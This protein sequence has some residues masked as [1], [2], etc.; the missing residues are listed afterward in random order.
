MTAKVYGYAEDD[1]DVEA[2]Q[3]FADVDIIVEDDKAER[4]QYRMLRRFLREGDTLFV[5]H[6]SALRWKD[7]TISAELDYLQQRQ[8]KLRVL[9]LPITL[10]D[11]DESAVS[12]MYQTL[13]EVM[14]AWQQRHENM[15]ILRSARQQ[16]GIKA[17]KKAGRRFGRPTIAYPRSWAQILGQWQAHEISASDA[18]RKLKMSRSTFYRMVKRYHQGEEGGPE[19]CLS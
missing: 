19:G 2:F 9:E 18:C 3:A 11:W 13:K 5:V 8:V 4:R 7:A 12:V 6:L 1:A 15:Q 16:E 17:A 10:Q 14:Q